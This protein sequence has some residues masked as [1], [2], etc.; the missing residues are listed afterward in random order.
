MLSG[1]FKEATTTLHQHL[2]AKTKE[3]FI[4]HL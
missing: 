4:A 3:A 2:G 1:C